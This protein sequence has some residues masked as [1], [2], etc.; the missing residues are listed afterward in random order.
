V[1]PTSYLELLSTYKK[2]LATERHANE[3]AKNRL[4]R[5]LEVLKEA[6]IQIDKMGKQ[7][8]ED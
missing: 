1:T 6:E 8:A 2:V 4:V 3:T 5:G 7:L